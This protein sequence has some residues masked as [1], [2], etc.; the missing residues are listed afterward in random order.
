VSKLN[1]LANKQTV[2]K[3]IEALKQN[4]ISSFFVENGKEAK[5]KVLELI[6]NKAEVLTMTS[7]TLDTIGL[8]KEINNSEDFVSVRNKLTSLDRNTQGLEMQKMGSAPEWSVGSVHAITEE[9]HV[10]IASNT[11][12]QLPGYSYG[13][14]HVIWIVGVQK[15][16]K[17]LDEA[18]KRVH[19]YVL[20]LESERAKKAYGVPG[21]RV[22]KMLIVNYEVNPSRSTVIFVNEELGF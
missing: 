16:V 11:G 8:A 20:P 10:V 4:N 9:G 7:V 21:S 12:S 14:Q 1:K 18:M 2:E 3:T 5:R 15:I 17:D 6:P 13:S 19:Q 22:S